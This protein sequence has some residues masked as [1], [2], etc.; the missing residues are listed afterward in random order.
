MEK[1]LVVDDLQDICDILSKLLVSEGYDVI[2]TNAGEDAIRLIKEE[3]IE[4]IFLDLILPE[5]DGIKVLGE[6]RKIDKD[7]AVVM[8]TAYP[9]TE[10][11]NASCALGVVDYITKP[12]DLDKIK[13]IVNKVSLE[14]KESRVQGVPG[15]SIKWRWRE[16]MDSITDIIEKPISDKVNGTTEH[17]PV[18]T[19]KKRIGELLVEQGIITEE[20]LNGAL[21]AQ[22]ANGKP[23]GENLMGLGFTTEK[24]I[25]K[26]LSI[27]Y[28]FPYLPLSNYTVPPH[29]VKIVPREF[30]LKY[31]LM[32]VD[33]IGNILTL[34]MADP[35]DEEAIF[36]VASMTKH[37]VKIYVSCGT[38]IL[39]AIER[40]YGKN[41]A[42]I[43]KEGSSDTLSNKNF[44]TL[45]SKW[46]KKIGIL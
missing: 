41:A 8:M 15:H 43:D 31:C 14:S 26:A 22:E 36:E 42:G 34:A 18:R 3:K 9:Q 10:T 21:K 23:I 19:I 11:F 24:E 7:V 39:D 44:S 45:I 46:K 30:A 35:L 28:G 29:I 16:R 20:E 25:V 27:Q 32:P 12:F 1:I 37:V 4:L 6:I 33:R 2:S 13:E 40:Y 5:M 38:E 17:I